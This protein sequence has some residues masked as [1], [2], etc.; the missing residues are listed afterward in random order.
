MDVLDYLMNHQYA[1]D[2]QSVKL[3]KYLSLVMDGCCTP[4]QKRAFQLRM[5]G[6]TFDE[7]CE[8]MGTKNKCT[9][10]RHVK[11][12]CRVIEKHLAY[13]QPFLEE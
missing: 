10:F 6:Y 4:K 9:S 5:K 12:A 11:K 8:K 3:Q 13:I 7:I 1:T 2:V